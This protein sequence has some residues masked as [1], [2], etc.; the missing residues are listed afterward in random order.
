MLRKN[1]VRIVEHV[2][3]IESKKVDKDLL[4][5]KQ[6]KI[7]KFS[8]KNLNAKDIIKAHKPFNTGFQGSKVKNLSYSP[9][10]ER[11]LNQNQSPLKQQMMQKSLYINKPQVGGLPTDTVLSKKRKTNAKVAWNTDPESK[12][13]D[14]SK[15]INRS[16][17]AK[18]NKLLSSIKSKI[19]NYHSDYSE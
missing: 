10:K 15:V 2:E 3:E 18:S 9:L 12:E 1:K 8:N 17:K 6:R 7:L 14:L 13:V 19:S 4:Y 5:G 11:G 16:F